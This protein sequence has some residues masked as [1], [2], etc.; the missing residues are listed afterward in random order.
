MPEAVNTGEGLSIM[1]TNNATA[2]SFSRGQLI[3]Q[4]N[5]EMYYDPTTSSTVSGRISIVPKNYIE[6]ALPVKNEGESLYNEVLSTVVN[7]GIYNVYCYEHLAQSREM[8]NFNGTYATRG[9]LLNLSYRVG[10]GA[11]ISEIKQ[12]FFCIGDEDTYFDGFAFRTLKPTKDDA[13]EPVDDWCIFDK[14]GSVQT[15]YSATPQQI[16]RWLDNTPIW[17]LGICH[18]FTSAERSELLNNS[19]GEGGV[20]Y[21]KFSP[22][23]LAKILNDN[24]KIKSFIINERLAGVFEET[25]SPSMSNDYRFEY[26]GNLY[27]QTLKDHL[28]TCNGIYGYI[29]IVAAEDSIKI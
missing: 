2:V 18:I 6:S 9:M 8:P 14:Y 5:G 10:V 21:I 23:E 29:E 19:Y 25:S 26:I 1:E 11:A 13:F 12:V 27:W 22:P 3:I 7:D 28:E 15:A 20:E 16:G 17:R 4:D 24:A